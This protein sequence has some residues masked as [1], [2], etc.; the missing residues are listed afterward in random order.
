MGF[1]SL[2][3]VTYSRAPSKL[4]RVGPICT[5]DNLLRDVPLFPYPLWYLMSHCPGPRSPLT[6]TCGLS[7]L[8]YS[9]STLAIGNTHHSSRKKS[10]PDDLGI[11]CG[12]GFTLPIASLLPIINSL[13]FSLVWPYTRL[14]GSLPSVPYHSCQLTCRLTLSIVLLHIVAIKSSKYCHTIPVVGVL[15]DLCVNADRNVVAMKS[16]RRR[17]GSNYGLTRSMHA[18]T[19][20]T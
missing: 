14:R 17:C 10:R 6:S 18:C 5:F 8:A 4:V 11:A 12:L 2:L 7:S 3:N 1:V 13:T 9:C 20:P 16:K 15:G 19:A